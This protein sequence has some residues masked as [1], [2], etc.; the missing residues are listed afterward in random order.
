MRPS[1]EQ[2]ARARPHGRTLLKYVYMKTGAHTVRIVAVVVIVDA[3]DG[4]A[5]TKNLT[6]IMV[7]KSV[8]VVV[9]VVAVVVDTTKGLMGTG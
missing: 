3:V 9:V 6:I 8:V 1:V 7:V 5:G 2:F 4:R